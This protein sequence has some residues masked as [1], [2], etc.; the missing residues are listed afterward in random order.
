MN[1]Q[2]VYDSII[3]SAKRSDRNKGGDEY[4]ESHHIIP[5]CM[6]GPDNKENLVLLT[7]REHFI[8]HWLLYKAN[9]SNY[10]LAKAFGMMMLSP[11]GNIRSSRY[12]DK[13]RKAFSE[14]QALMYENMSVE[15]RRMKFGHGKGGRHIRTEE[16][17]R[18]LKEMDR[19]YLKTEEY[20]ENMSIAT[21]GEK[22]GM[23]G[24]KHTE[25]SK[26]KMSDCRIPEEMSKKT[27]THWDSLSEEQRKERTKNMSGP[28]KEQTCPHCGKTGRGGNMKRYHFDNCKDVG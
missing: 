9:P 4:Y 12:F 1:Y 7:G 20:R 15:E 28:R 11:Q 13:C 8:C 26:R 27:K 10:K 3:D 17:I 24:K 6:G 14:A 21:A 18:I 16:H 23:Y 19:S 2:K 5:S 25:E 22:N